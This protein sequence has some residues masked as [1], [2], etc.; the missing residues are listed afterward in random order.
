MGLYDLVDQMLIHS[1][2]PSG[3]LETNFHPD[4]DDPVLHECFIQD[5]HLIR[6]HELMGPHIWD[7]V[8]FF[9][10]QEFVNWLLLKHIEEVVGR[11]LGAI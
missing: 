6:L 9:A 2:L 3:G 8:P 1:P 7:H 5:L 10:A 11:A 4:N